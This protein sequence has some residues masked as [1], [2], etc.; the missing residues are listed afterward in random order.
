MQGDRAITTGVVKGNHHF[1]VVD[2]HRVDESLY[3]LFL[4]S[5]V[6]VIHIDKPV[7]EIED[8]L[9]FQSQV[10]PQLR[11]RQRVL[12]FRLLFAWLVYM[13]FRRVVEYPGLDC[14]E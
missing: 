12:K 11:R 7:Q 6:G 2:E 9:F 8:M 4:T 13:L 14:S 5:L 3:Q 10:L 1:V